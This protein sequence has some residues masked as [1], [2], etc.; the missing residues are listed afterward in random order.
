MVLPLA[1]EIMSES[2]DQID[3]MSFPPPPSPHAE[4]SDDR[5][6]EP[7]LGSTMQQGPLV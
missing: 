5:I 7:S 4:M 1:G 2:V 6:Q 3:Q